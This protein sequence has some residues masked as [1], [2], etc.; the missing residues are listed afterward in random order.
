VGKNAKPDN[1]KPY[2]AVD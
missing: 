1:V 2:L